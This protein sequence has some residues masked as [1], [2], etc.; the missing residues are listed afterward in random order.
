[1]FKIAKE[2]KNKIKVGFSRGFTLLEL[3]VVLTIMSIVLALGI[4]SVGKVLQ[5]KG[6][7]LSEEHMDKVRTA[8]ERYKAG[9]G[10][11]PCPAR[12][13]LEVGHADFGKEAPLT[14]DTPAGGNVC[15]RSPS[16]DYNNAQTLGTNGFV[17]VFDAGASTDAQRWNRSVIIGAIPVQELGIDK[18]Y[19][20]DKWGN[21]LVYAVTE[22]LAADT[23][24]STPSDLDNATAA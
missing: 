24:D 6:D 19:A 11:Y 23:S 22:K 10:R 15:Y 20:V 14:I 18:K 7:N 17:R 2:L 13:N 4:S 16:A 21:K 5:S 3:T 1:M 8:L 9:N 12:L